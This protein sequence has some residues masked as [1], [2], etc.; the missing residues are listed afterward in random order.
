VSS[1][2]AMSFKEKIVL[3]IC[4]KS[5]VEDWVNHFR[6][7]YSYVPEFTYDL[8]DKKQFQTFFEHCE[9]TENPTTETCFGVINYDLI[10]RKKQFLN[11]KD[12]TLILDE[13]SVIRNE[14]TQR[15]KFVMKMTPTNIIMLTGT[16]CGG[17]YENL[18]TQLHLL[19]WNISEKIYNAQ[20]VN[21]KNIFVGG[22]IHKVVDK[23][24]PYKNVE[25]LKQKMRDHGAVFMKTE[26]VFALPTQNFV[27]MNVPATKEYKK[28]TRNRLVTVDG[29]EFVGD[30][31]LSFRLYQRQLCSAYNP[32]KIQTFRDIL[33]STQDRLIVFY[34]FNCELVEL[35]AAC[36]DL[37]R[38]YSMVNGSIKNLSN[39]EQDS[40]SVTLV[41]YKAGAMGLNLQKA[42]KIIY[43]SL[44][45]EAELFEQSK[46]RIHRIGQNKPCFYYMLICQNSIEDQEILPTLNIRKDYTDELFKENF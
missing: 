2:K 24:D 26:E 4:Q 25:R 31:T 6:I 7:N 33:E 8:T 35:Q 29:I 45:E 15:A 43:F 30:S 28:F 42:N 19:G 41:Q 36:N 13:S 39:Y 46:K 9:A 11:L 22:M 27:M 14:K 34:N 21:W 44:T 16:I 5:K 20:Y 40:N 1:E 12:Y 23:D 3:I 37:E 17:K 10:F 38:P 32:H 18:Y